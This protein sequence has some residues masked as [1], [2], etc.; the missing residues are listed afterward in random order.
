MPPETEVILELAP[1]PPP[2][3]ETTDGGPTPPMLMAGMEDKS[4]KSEANPA[5]KDHCDCSF[6]RDAA[7][8]LSKPNKPKY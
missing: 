5:A 1:T 4:S 8:F 3:K 2:E 6:C 7:E